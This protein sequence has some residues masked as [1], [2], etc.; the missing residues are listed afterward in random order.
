MS[1]E[2][3]SQN[4]LPVFLVFLWLPDRP[5]T[6]KSFKNTVGYYK[7][8]VLPKS[9]KV[10][11]GSDFT[12][13]LELLLAPLDD[14]CA[15]FSLKKRCRKRTEKTT[16]KNTKKKPV[17]AREREARLKIELVLATAERETNINR[18]GEEKP[19]DTSRY[20]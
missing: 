19:R 17:L 15:Y 9:E 10:S 3:A 7:N 20:L 1:S 2:K 16:R 8:E 5:R 13:I 6:P 11:S 14:I 4:L 12:S 18:K